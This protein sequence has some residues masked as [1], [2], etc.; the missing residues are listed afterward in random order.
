LGV[1]VKINNTE[2]KVLFS[3]LRTGD[4]EIGYSAWAADVNDA[5]NFLAVLDGRSSNSNYARY[6]NATYDQLLDS[7]ASTSDA[8]GRAT[9]LSAAESL[10]LKDAPIAPLVHGVSKNLVGTHVSGWVDNP[11]DIHLSRYLKVD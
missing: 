5:G 3:R 11:R 6:K 7:A 1:N 4:F 9:I 8:T 10:M 2:G